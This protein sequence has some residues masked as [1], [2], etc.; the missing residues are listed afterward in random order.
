[1]HYNVSRI[2]KHHD[3]GTEDATRSQETIHE[4]RE[5]VSERD[6]ATWPHGGTTEEKWAA[7]RTA[8]TESA[9]TALGTEQGKHPDCFQESATLLNLYCR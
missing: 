8:L 9:D 7:L 1:M 3:R 6:S 2:V 4:L 5:Q